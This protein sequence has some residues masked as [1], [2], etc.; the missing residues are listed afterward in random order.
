MFRYSLFDNLD[1]SVYLC[2][3]ISEMS[4]RYVPFFGAFRYAFGDAERLMLFLQFRQF[5]MRTYYLITLPLVFLPQR[6]IFPLQRGKTRDQ[7]L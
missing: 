6:V 1:S 4:F 2:D 7:R 3:D 5:G